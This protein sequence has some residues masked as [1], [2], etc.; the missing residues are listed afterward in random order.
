MEKSW[1]FLNNICNSS[2][3]FVFESSFSQKAN[4]NN[5]YCDWYNYIFQLIHNIKTNRIRTVLPV[6][7]TFIVPSGKSSFSNI[8]ASVYLLAASCCFLVLQ[9]ALLVIIRKSTNDTCLFTNSNWL[10][11]DDTVCSFKN[12]IQDHVTGKGIFAGKGMEDVNFSRY[13]DDNA[14]R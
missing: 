4:R 2:F 13:N 11:N 5:V 3:C 10:L 14:S 8:K 12:F 6:A 9:V 1:V 7:V